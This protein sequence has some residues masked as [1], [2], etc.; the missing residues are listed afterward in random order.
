MGKREQQFMQYALDERE[1]V[2]ALAVMMPTRDLAE[3]LFAQDVRWLG[4][5]SEMASDR[6]RL[7][8]WRNRI[9][10]RFGLQEG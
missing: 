8:N 2:F 6:D 4:T 3:A 7:A 1:K 9:D 5:A 10:V